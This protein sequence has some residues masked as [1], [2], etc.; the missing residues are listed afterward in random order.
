VAKLTP[1]EAMFDLK[2]TLLFALHLDRLS[3]CA[4][5]LL[6]GATSAVVLIALAM[7]LGHA[8]GLDWLWELH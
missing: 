7:M 2:R 1:A 6:A 3:P 4:F 5:G 8:L